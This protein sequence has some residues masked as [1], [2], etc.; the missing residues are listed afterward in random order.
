MRHGITFR[1]KH[2]NDIGVIVKTVGR[3]FS[4]PVKQ[5]DEEVQYRDGNIDLSETGGRLY[6]EDKVL[7]LEFQMICPDNIALQRSASKLV[8]WL[9]GG[10]G[11]LIFDDMPTVKW[12]AKPVDLDDMKIE[13]Y[14][15]SKATVQFRCR[16]FND[17]R[18][19]SSGIPLDSD[20][21]LDCDLPIGMGDENE[22]SFQAGT[23]EN[24]MIYYGSAPVRP[25]C[26]LSL[27]SAVKMLDVTVNGVMVRII[28]ESETNIIIDCEKA[29]MPE[30]C[31]GDF[32]ELQPGENTI[33]II[34]TGGQGVLK[35]VYN[36]KLLY[37]AEF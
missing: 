35:F 34:C 25:G 32:F 27:S 13:L 15:N 30:I 16:P 29:I 4:P 11:E 26:E 10:Y 28:P 31:E 6:Y 7:E 19:N 21:I 17:W 5:I 36:H 37:G 24:T 3:P 20:I 23:T 33:K 1:G 12:I 14:K 9:S 18:Y 22:I 2:S 8:N